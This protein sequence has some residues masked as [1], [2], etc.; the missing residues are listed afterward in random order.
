MWCTTIKN[1][2]DKPSIC[3]NYFPPVLVYIG[4]FGMLFICSSLYQNT[5]S[6]YMIRDLHITG[7]YHM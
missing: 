6:E 3:P 4:Y 2:K 5:F 7:M 1:V